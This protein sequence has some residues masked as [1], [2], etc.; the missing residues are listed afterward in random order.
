MTKF[1]SFSLP[2]LF[3]LSCNDKQ[4]SGGTIDIE[5]PLA[6]VLKL[7]TA[8]SFKDYETAKKFVDL[9]KTYGRIAKENNKDPETV[10]KEYVEFNYAV[11][12][13]SPKF[14]NI[15]PFHKYKISE[16]NKKNYFEVK[17]TSLNVE[18][19]IKQVVYSLE[20]RGKQ[21][22]IVGIDYIK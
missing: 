12:N 2:V 14:I 9:G 21:W 22:M 4:N 18:Q 3:L 5:S 6:I 8:E 16:S 11:G 10:W 17:L 1:L 15:F 19:K 20:L 13:S 7:E